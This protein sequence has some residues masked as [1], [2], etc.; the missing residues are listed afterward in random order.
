MKA[1][2]RKPH[3]VVDVRR[4]KEIDDLREAV[5][6]LPEVRTEKVTAVKKAI[7]SGT[8]V[9]DAAKIA[10]RMIDEML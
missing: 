5:R 6:A 3:V 10:Q 8:Y 7:E 1:D 4:A 2:G 9:V